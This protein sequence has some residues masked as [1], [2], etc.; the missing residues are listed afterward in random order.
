MPFIAIRC[1]SQVFEGNRVYTYSFTRTKKVYNELDSPTSNIVKRENITFRVDTVLI[2]GKNK[3]LFVLDKCL[4]YFLRSEYFPILTDSAATP[5]EREMMEGTRMKDAPI[6][7][8]SELASLIYQVE[9]VT[10]LL[11]IPKY[12]IQK[13]NFDKIFVADLSNKLSKTISKNN[14]FGI[15]QIS[16]S[17]IFIEGLSLPLSPFLIYKGGTEDPKYIFGKND[18]LFDFYRFTK[19]EKFG[20]STE[21]FDLYEH[22]YEIKA[23]FYEI[24]KV[25]LDPKRRNLI[26][27]VRTIYDNFKNCYYTNVLELVR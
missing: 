23:T 19:L 15:Y 4:N 9:N 12:L 16:N 5:E 26:K 6:N 7:N 1:N 14:E 2:L 25:Y 20:K 27:S 21:G 24:A 18:Y 17:F 22:R 3:K 13:I 11:T 10:Y 8:D